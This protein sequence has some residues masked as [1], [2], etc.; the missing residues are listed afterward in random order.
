MLH[1]EYRL[2]SELY[3][4]APYA[5]ATEVYDA[6]CFDNRALAIQTQLE[7]TR[8]KIIHCPPAIP[9]ICFVI[10]HDGNIVHVAN[11]SPCV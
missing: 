4:V 1:L 6:A 9:Q 3:M 8:E 7:M 2:L 11:I 10:A 5:M